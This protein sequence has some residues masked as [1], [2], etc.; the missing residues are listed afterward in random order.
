MKQKLYKISFPDQSGWE[1]FKAANLL[2]EEGNMKPEFTVAG[3][4]FEEGDP[5]SII[6]NPESAPASASRGTDIISG[7]TYYGNSESGTLI[8][9]SSAQNTSAVKLV[10]IDDGTSVNSIYLY[11]YTNQIATDIRNVNGVQWSKGVVVSDVTQENT[12]AVR[13]KTG[14]FSLWVN[15]VKVAEQ[16]SGS[17][18]VGMTKVAMYGL[19]SH[20]YGNIQELITTKYLTD[21]EIENLE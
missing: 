16:L 17:S 20:F 12:Y 21:S 7:A 19:G 3:I 2:D 15:G 4:Q 11:I 13:W 18:P 1:A 5:T 8:L 14:E 10:G 9:K 6:A